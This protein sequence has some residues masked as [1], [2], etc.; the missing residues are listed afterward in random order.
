MPLPSLS[1]RT[2]I[3]HI[4]RKIRKVQDYWG[5]LIFIIT[6][7]SVY[8]NWN[9]DVAQWSCAGIAQPH[10]DDFVAHKV[11]NWSPLQWMIDYIFRCDGIYLGTVVQESHTA[12]PFI[13]TLAMFPNLYHCW[14]GSRF[15]K[16]VCEMVFTPLKSLSGGA[17]WCSLLSEGCGF[18]LSMQSPPSHLT[19]SYL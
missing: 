3:W 16:G 11:G 6:P 14:K 15:K 1:T 18:P 7:N 4:S 8:L 13:F 10:T 9:H 2:W 17:W 5:Y 19:I 12:P